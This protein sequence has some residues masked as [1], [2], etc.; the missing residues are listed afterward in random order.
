[1]KRKL[2]I[3]ITALFALLITSCGNGLSVKNDIPQNMGKIVINAGVDTSARHYFPTG[4]EVDVSKFQGFY[5]EAKNTKTN[6]SIQLVSNGSFSDFSEPLV[7]AEGTYNFTLTAFKHFGEN[8]DDLIQ[9]TDT[10]ED[11]Q[12]FAKQTNKLSFTLEPADSASAKGSISLTVTFDNSKNAVDMVL[13]SLYTVNQ[14]TG[15]IIWM[16]EI[17]EAGP[18][19][20]GT[21]YSNTSTETISCTKTDIEPGVYYLDLT[22]YTGVTDNYWLID[23]YTFAYIFV[24]GGFD[25]ALSETV[26][27][28]PIYTITYK[29]EDGTVIDATALGWQTKYTRKSDYVLGEL[30]KDGYRFLGWVDATNPDGEPFGDFEEGSRGD[31]TLI[32]KFEE[33]SIPVYFC[34]EKDDLAHYDHEIKTIDYYK[35]N[36]QAFLDEIDSIDEDEFV[37]SPAN[38]WL[39]EYPNGITTEQLAAL[40]EEEESFY[41]WYDRIYSISYTNYISDATSTGTY[42][43]SYTQHTPSFDLPVLSKEDYIFLGWYNKSDLDV[44]GAT[45]VPKADTSPITSIYGGRGDL[46][47]QA[48]WKN[49]TNTGISINLPEEDEDTFNLS[50]T[51]QIKCTPVSGGGFKMQILPKDSITD[52]EERIQANSQLGNYTYKWNIDGSLVADATTSEFTMAQADC[53]TFTPNSIHYVLVAATKDGK[54]YTLSQRIQLADE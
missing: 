52:S 33:I 35:S 6:E 32:A 19:L 24:Y 8:E 36:N 14:E 45:A 49:K 48:I 21:D 30:E 18:L 1:M 27:L 34:Y 44:S 42:V 39:S 43:R 17:M 5:L 47:L 12:I 29:N 2:L 41:I 25:T 28:N 15:E 22:F 50:D 7:I 4:D 26:K 40:I 51:Y 23:S 13:P 37:L 10:L 16:E 54:T 53:P 46:E 3:C 38:T 9:F 20:K 31:K 11:I